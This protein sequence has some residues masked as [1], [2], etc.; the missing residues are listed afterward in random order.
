MRVW[1]QVTVQP[2]KMAKLLLR[3]RPDQPAWPDDLIFSEY[4][5]GDNGTAIGLDPQ[6]RP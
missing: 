6:A 2:G 1:Y 5:Y 4:F 3:L